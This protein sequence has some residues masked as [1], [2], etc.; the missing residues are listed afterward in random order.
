MRIVTI[1]LLQAVI[2]L[3]A[4]FPAHALDAADIVQAAFDYWRGKTSYSVVQ[5][6]VHR[7]AWER[8]FSIR[9]WTKGQDRSLFHII[10]P[11]RDKGNGTLKKGREMWMFNPKVNRVIKIPPSMMSQAWMGSD[12]SNDDLAK[13]DSLLEDYTHRLADTEIHE[14]KKVYI[15]E[16]IP[17]P[18]APV[19]W[20]MQRLKVREDH[21]FLEEIFFDEDRKPVKAM[22]AH[23]IEMIEGRLFPRSWKMRK[24]DVNDEYTLL[25]YDEL[26]F[27]MA[28]PDSVF[29]LTSLKNPKMR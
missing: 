3:S 28:I 17:K 20:G 12:F 13:S 27:D 24:A 15:I 18:A 1:L 16:S 10:A 4:N 2:L 19:V 22:S 21:I 11:P 29:T 9:A 26:K 5:M 14:G 25:T 6:T 7:P 23:Q 8:V